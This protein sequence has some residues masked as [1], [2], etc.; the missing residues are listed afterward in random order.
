[1]SNTKHP[2][3]L[4]LCA[5]MKGWIVPTEEIPDPVFAQKMLGDGAG[6]DPTGST[7]HA[8]CDATILSIHRAG[9]AITFR[10]VSGVE[11]LMHIGLDTVSLEH[12]GF[13]VLV[14]ENQWVKIG[15]PLINFD[16]DFLALH[17][18]SL[19]TPI[20]ITN[21]EQ[22]QIVR[23]ERNRE[24]DTGQFLMELARTAGT[25]AN[26][27]A[28]TGPVEREVAVPLLHG[29]HVRP[30]ARI[31]HLAK[32]YVSDVFIHA[33]GRAANAKSPVALM[34]L[35]IGHR[36]TVR[37]SAEGADAAAA[38]AALAILIEGG[39]GEAAEQPSEKQR[40]PVSAPGVGLPIQLSVPGL[41]RGVT[42]APGLAI[43]RATVFIPRQ[44]VVRETAVDPL[45]E[46]AD[47]DTALVRVRARIRASAAAGDF[48]RRNI[49]AAHLEMLDDPE[50]LHAAREHIAQGA[51]AGVSWRYAMRGHVHALRDSRDPRFQERIDDL[52][53]LER[54]VLTALSGE[55]AAGNKLAA[56][57]ILLADE[58][59][60]SQIMALESSQ[61]AGLCTVKG[62]PTSHVAILAA[63]MGLPTI[64]AADADILTIASGTL[65]ILD[66]D[67][68]TVRV[69]PDAS[70]LQAAR[71]D[72]ARRRARQLAQSDGAHQESVMAD[73]RHIEVFANVGSVTD[74]RTA[75]AAGADG[76]GLVRSEFLFLDRDQPPSEEEQ[77][78]EYQAIAAAFGGRSV[79][80]RTLDIGGDKA[81]PYLSFPHE[82][83]PA[84]GM[85]GVRISL[86]RP[87]LLKTQLRAILKV[88]PAGQCKIMIPMIAS[89]EELRTVRALLA[90]T[91][92]ELGS[93]LPE[94]GVMIE[95]PAAAMTAD[96]LSQ[97]ADFFS[98]GTNDLT[99]YTLAM[100]RGN[101]T[102]AAQ[103]DA[104]HPA[105]L[106][107]IEQTCRGAA[108]GNRWVGVCGGLASDPLAAPILIGLGVTELS[109]ASSAIPSI[110]AIV[111][112]LTVE[113]CRDLAAR[114]LALASPHAVRQLA[115]Q[116][117]ESRQ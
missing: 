22:F 62:G 28:Q 3:N 82:E 56:G 38:V 27:V 106:R 63:S 37:L 80:V 72:L 105:I 26:E 5:P 53:D 102:L 58:L 16:I 64:V 32:E 114:S 31:A 40:P 74:A 30:A 7:L 51:S 44:I 48:A 35:S 4:I 61:L 68:G 109:V 66:A 111:R 60:P 70:T 78:Q 73:G 95:T 20:I 75:A 46:R 17:A 87:A 67:L 116:F 8:P 19:I 89:L 15:E 14:R 101:P 50:L 96:L 29:L 100:D 108:R 45:T 10:T 24:I 76:C 69:D 94:L 113:R 39:M 11:I 107:L 104:M 103:V 47:L 81:A 79:I 2:E 1:M 110:K 65:L 59:L 88:Q 18:R 71:A 91:A 115:L 93:V 9:H 92:A 98:I 55:S 23:C 33:H 6:I 99:Q 97:E 112:Q 42:A 12:K 54:Q 85:R 13:D 52:I 117:M 84:L 49:L 83:N 41:L 77:A 57:T 36:E 21:L 25:P 86:S 34:T 43:G 90:E